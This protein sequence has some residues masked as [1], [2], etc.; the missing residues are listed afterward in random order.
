MEAHCPEVKDVHLSKRRLTRLVSVEF[1]FNGSLGE[2]NV[3]AAK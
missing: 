1:P 3:C 2:R